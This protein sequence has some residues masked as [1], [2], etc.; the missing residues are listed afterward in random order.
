MKYEGRMKNSKMWVLQGVQ[1]MEL[2]LI[3]DLIYLK[4]QLK[5][6]KQKRWCSKLYWT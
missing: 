3:F 2:N 6:R 5:A 1:K 4:L